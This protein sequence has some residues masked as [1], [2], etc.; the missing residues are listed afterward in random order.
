[1]KIS[2]ICSDAEHP[3]NAYIELWTMRHRNNHKIE[4]V[5][6]KKELSG[7]DILFLVSCSE[8]ISAKERALYRNTMVLHAS[9][10][11]RGRGWSPHIWEIIAGASSITLSLLEAEDK[12]DSGRIWKKR[13]IAVPKDALWNEINDLLFTAELDLMDFAVASF[14]K[15][16]P[17]VQS[18][19]V[20]ETYFRRRTNK[21]SYV[22][23]QK[24]IAEQFDLIRVC[25]PFRFPAYFE[26]R[27]HT[28][29]IKLEKLN[30]E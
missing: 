20:E 2:I 27:G 1:M 19:D 17:H 18:S 6:R 22:D 26:F 13:H 28:Y 23:P 10:L 11:P 8:I 25:D 29:S 14:E 15:C 9:D 24:S 4:L 30:E 12:V 16:Q 5:R 7:G 3:V 21:D